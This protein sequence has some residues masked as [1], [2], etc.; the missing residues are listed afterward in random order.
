MKILS[1]NIR[2]LGGHAKKKRNT[3]VCVE[4]PYVQL[5]VKCFG[6]LKTFSSSSNHSKGHQIVS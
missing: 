4:K 5:F 3:G 1:Y 6:G 2:G